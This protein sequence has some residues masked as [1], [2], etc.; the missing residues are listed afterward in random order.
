[1]FVFRLS[2]VT[3]GMLGSSLAVFWLLGNSAPLPLLMVVAVVYFAGWAVIF[4][5]IGKD[6]TADVPITKT[7][8]LFDL[9]RGFILPVV[10]LRP[11][12]GKSLF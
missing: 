7:K 4:V 2:L 12:F 3:L 10:L 8:L 5:S 11:L 6:F 1:M 9:V